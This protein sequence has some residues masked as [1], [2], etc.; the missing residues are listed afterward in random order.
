MFTR[1]RITVG[2][3]Q[4][5]AWSPD[6]CREILAAISV[7]AAY[8][9]L[10]LLI[11]GADHRRIRG[12]S[13]RPASLLAVVR[14]RPMGRKIFAVVAATCAFA[15]VV[16]AGAS[17]ATVTTVATGLDNPRGLA[18][19]PNGTLAVGEAGHGGDV[20]FADFCVGATSQISMIDLSTGAHTPLVTGLF[21]LTLVAEHAVLGVGGLSAQ[22]G[23]LLAVEGE[24]PQELDGVSCA[25]QPADC[26]QVLA[27]ARAT[28]G[29]LGRV[30]PSGA[31]KTLA[32]VGAFDF[33]FTAANPGGAT[34][35]SEVDANPYGLLA[36][37]GGTFVADAA[38]NTLDWVDNDG[39]ISIVDRFVVPSP[40]EAFPADAVPTCV[41]RSTSGQLY[42]GDLAGRIWAES[43]GSASLVSGQSAHNHYTGCVADD[44]GNVYFVSIFNGTGGPTPMTGSV[45]KLAANGTL[46]TVV[47]PL[48]FPNKDAIGPD[49]NLYVSI[50][51]VCPAVG[52]CTGG[53]VRISP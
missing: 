31:W 29:T 41:A 1:V 53:I 38:S 24:Y 32:G 46:S 15:L 30:T 13:G 47:A 19:L 44:A 10:D 26:A 40:P 35:G 20:C 43:D 52:L 37:P 51:S 45:V 18:F 8:S 11:E 2:Q 7:C 36:L 14:R 42:V 23:R 12:S 6:W 33:N 25:G 22:G 17:A 49:G 48:N 3:R 5:A 28:A 39:G 34:F 27:A 50:N 21:S 16:V 4:P 9:L